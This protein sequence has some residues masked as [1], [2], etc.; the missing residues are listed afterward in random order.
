[1]ENH[2]GNKWFLSCKILIQ[3]WIYEGRMKIN[4]PDYL[5]LK[6]WG[7]MTPLKSQAS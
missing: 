4:L 7:K 2:V 6:K 3:K 5:N 1:M